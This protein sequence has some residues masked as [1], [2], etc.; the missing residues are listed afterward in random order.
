[1]GFCAGKT[2]PP[3][4]GNVL[5]SLIFFSHLAYALPGVLFCH[6]DQGTIKTDIL[7]YQQQLK[8]PKVHTYACNKDNIPHVYY[9]PSFAPAKKK[10]AKKEKKKKKKKRDQ[11]DQGVP[12]YQVQQVRTPY[13][14]CMGNI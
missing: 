14:A 5:A 12:D 9:T 11:D 8:P 6:R 13:N 2:A 4:W 1:V 7:D 3:R 10:K